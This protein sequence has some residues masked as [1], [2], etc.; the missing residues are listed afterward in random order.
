[1][2]THPLI[3]SHPPDQSA[4]PRLDREKARTFQGAFRAAASESHHHADFL[5]RISRILVDSAKADVV[6]IATGPSPS[7]LVLQGVLHPVEGLAE[8]TR[9]SFL[10]SARLALQENQTRVGRIG[11][12]PNQ[13]LVSL[14]ITVGTT[15][16]VFQVLFLT[17]I[18][19]PDALTTIIELA[20]ANLI[21]FRLTQQN[22]SLDHESKHLAAI[23]DLVSRIESSSSLQSAGQIACDS[24]ARHLNASQVTIGVRYSD[25][26]ECRILA[27]SRSEESLTPDRRVILLEAALNESIQRGEL[28]TWPANPSDQCHSLATHR[29]LVEHSQSGRVISA[30]LRSHQGE[31]VGAWLVRFD[32][33]DTP[34]YLLNFVQAAATPVGSALLAMRRSEK[35]VLA[36]R[37]LQITTQIRHRQG[38]WITALCLLAIAALWI[39]LPYQVR[40][41][42]EINPVSLRY[43]TAPFDARLLHAVVSPGDE[44]AQDQ[45]LAQL[46][47]EE[48][49]VELSGATAEVDRAAK[50]RDGHLAEKEIN[51]AQVSRLEMARMDA[52]ARL[53]RQR[54]AQLEIRSPVTGV[55]IS[56]D[57]RQSEGAPLTTGQTMFEIA[58]L[59]EMVLEIGIS[60]SDISHVKVGQAIEAVLNSLPDRTWTG[61]IERIHPR[62]DLVDQDYVFVAEAHFQNQANLLR[63][64][65]KGR[66]KITAASH[67]LGWNLFHKAIDQ[68]R[69]W[70]G[71]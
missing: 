5:S 28:G 22:L 15:L 45:L 57:L 60:E 37:W 40:A 26:V 21:Q 18:A 4:N 14:P 9:L 66:V 54:N 1:M 51:A 20:V 43:V 34:S 69:F 61:S 63:P 55:V 19:A 48:L 10:D 29:Q 58:P 17:P 41:S 65:M 27:S 23:A 24:V 16:E 46:D 50:E 52:K 32:S 56:G 3:Q 30:P 39:P 59:D 71:W 44:V 53:L 11:R 25:Q 38:R 62:A 7:Q 31:I 33:P 47:G 13:L 42:C 8:D 64:G 12:P 2:S 36:K 35:S 67:P 70:V 6:V 68:V 49:R